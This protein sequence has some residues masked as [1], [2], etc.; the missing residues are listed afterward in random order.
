MLA[1]VG[2]LRFLYPVLLIV[3]TVAFGRRYFMTRMHH[4][5]HEVW[6]VDKSGLGYRSRERAIG[7]WGDWGRKHRYGRVGKIAGIIWP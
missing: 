1:S 7:A 5:L 6:Q 2:W 3:A 4:Y